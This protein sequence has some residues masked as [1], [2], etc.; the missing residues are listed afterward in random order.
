MLKGIGI[1]IIEVQRIEKALER[2]PRF[3]Q[4][5]FTER[6]ITQC[7]SKPVPAESFAARFAAKEAVFK[8]LGSGWQLGW[9]SIEIISD[10]LG[11]PQVTLEGK[12][13]DKAVEL[14]IQEVK[15]SLTHTRQY[16]AAVAI[17]VGAVAPGLVVSR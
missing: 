16:A 7:R 12:A 14:G 11:R 8:T 5:L 1:D 2:T 3:Q 9:S 6:E 10:A 4:R 17:A 15:V 13:A